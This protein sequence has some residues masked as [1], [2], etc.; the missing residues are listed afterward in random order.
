MGKSLQDIVNKD[1]FTLLELEHLPQ[2]K[3]DELF[4]EAYETIMNQ[5]MLRIADLLED[6]LEEFKTVLDQQDAEKALQYL[7]DKGVNLEQ[8]VAEESLAYKLQMAS[9]Q[10]ALRS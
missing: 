9:I 3:K 5:V 10:E 1:I 7:M 8:L 6:N 4:Q 2:E